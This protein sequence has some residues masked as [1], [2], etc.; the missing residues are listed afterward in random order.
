VQSANLVSSGHVAAG[1]LIT[2]LDRIGEHC[3][4]AIYI[5]ATNFSKKTNL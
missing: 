4:A 1:A 5:Y 3:T 2:E